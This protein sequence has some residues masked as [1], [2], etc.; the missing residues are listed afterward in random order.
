[1]ASTVNVRS[2]SNPVGG[3]SIAFVQGS[4]DRTPQAHVTGAASD[5]YYIEVDNSLNTDASYLKIYDQ[6]GSPTHGTTDPMLVVKAAGS[7]LATI[8]VPGSFDLSNGITMLVSTDGGRGSGS[9][10]LISQDVTVTVLTA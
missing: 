1:M 3:K 8:A 10:D 7:S 9:S 6:T 5:I 2:I 4:K